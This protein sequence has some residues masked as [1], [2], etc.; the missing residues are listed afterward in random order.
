MTCFYCGKKLEGRKRKYCNTKCRTK[1]YFEKRQK[2]KICH[3]CGEKFKYGSW[4]YCSKCKSGIGISALYHKISEKTCVICNK[5]YL[6]GGHLTCS[7]ICRDIYNKEYFY[8]WAQKNRGTRPYTYE[9][10]E[11]KIKALREMHAALRKGTI[12]RK[13]CN[14][15]GDENSEGHHEDY[16]KPLDIIWLCKKHHMERHAELRRNKLKNI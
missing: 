13:S 11:I 7:K 9:K 8:K 16:T 15:C 10:T 4:G 2:I 12:S 14:V 5:K 3:N 6:R 1:D